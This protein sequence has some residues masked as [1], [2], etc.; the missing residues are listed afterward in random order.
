MIACTFGRLDL[1]DLLLQSVNHYRLHDD[2]RGEIIEEMRRKAQEYVDR[3]FRPPAAS[4]PQK[5]RIR[6]MSCPPDRTNG[7]ESRQAADTSFYGGMA[8]L[9]FDGDYLFVA[10]PVDGRT[11][12]HRAVENGKPYIV[13]KILRVNASCVNVPDADGMTALHL[14]CQKNN[15]SVVRKFL[16][17]LSQ[18]VRLLF[19]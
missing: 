3:S 6:S 5:E 9:S 10:S 11:A 7:I 1:L 12:L 4:T 17:C 2:E 15:T 19:D 18:K 13:G 16:V 8:S 14:A